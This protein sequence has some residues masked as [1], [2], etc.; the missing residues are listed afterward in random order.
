MTVTA[1][2]NATTAQNISWSAGGNFSAVGGG[3]TPCGSLLNPAAS[4][5][6]SVTFSPTT[7][8]TGGVVKGGLAVSD[9]A[10]GVL[11]NPQSV[12][13][14][15]A[16]TGGPPSNPL[17]FSPAALNFGN[18]AIGSSKTGAAQILNA[19]GS[20]L[21][22]S[23]IRASG[24]YTVSGSGARPCSNGLVLA[25]NAKC[26]ISVTLTPTSSGS[27]V[28]SVTVVDTAASGPTTQTYNVTATGF[29][30]I[31]LSPSTLTFPTTA[32]GVTSSALQ[33]TVTNYTS[34]P[35]TL[36][37]MVASGDFGVVL[38]GT[39]PCVTNTILSASGSCTFGV[40]FSPAV[41]GAIS[42]AVTVSHTAPNSPQIVSLA[43]TGH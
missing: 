22:L 8:G 10:M 20:S 9:G 31:T 34:G 33:V 6:L 25:A 1:T 26:G 29:W 39:T 27:I 11:Y 7:N 5:T 19:S 42:G 38:L 36:N 21:T 18:M 37:S 16:A 12:N 41:T 32:V 2:N 3:A 4:C 24:E 14:S 40:T 30:P 28:G 17:A 23:S 15:G 13:L 43:G 35:V